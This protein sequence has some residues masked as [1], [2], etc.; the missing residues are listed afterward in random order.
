MKFKN[1]FTEG[2]EVVCISDNFPLIKEYGGDGNDTKKKP[3]KGE[4]LV[5]N[6][7]LGEF[8]MFEKYNDESINWWFYNRFVLIDQITEMSS[9]EKKEKPTF[10]KDRKEPQA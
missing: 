1:P 8:L 7:V 4:I 3:K 10:P 2:Q 9:L 5:I 6:E